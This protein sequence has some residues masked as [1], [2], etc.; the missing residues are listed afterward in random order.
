MR[1]WELQ[2]ANRLLSARLNSEG[3]KTGFSGL[4]PTWLW[5]LE[6]LPFAPPLP[7]PLGRKAA[8]AVRNA[9]RQKPIDVFRAGWVADGIVELAHPAAPELPST[10][11]GGGSLPQLPQQRPAPP[12]VGVGI[13]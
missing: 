3:K 9:R 5:A 11:F 7:K 1:F 12:G 4:Q 10:P 2:I 6:C 8:V 13:D